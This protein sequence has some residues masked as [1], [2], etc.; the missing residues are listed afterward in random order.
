MDPSW[1]GFFHH[2]SP[3]FGEYVAS[4]FP[5]HLSVPNLRPLRQKN[6]TKNT[7]FLASWMFSHEPFI[8]WTINLAMRHEPINPYGGQL[9]K[10]WVSPTTMGVFLL[11]MTK[12]WGVKWVFFPPF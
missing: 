3:A 2:F 8:E 6:T 11:K 4:S 12:H 9:L 10:W 5:K 7:K 1:D